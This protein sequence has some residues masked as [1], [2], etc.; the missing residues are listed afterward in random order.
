MA[1]VMKRV[2][3]SVIFYLGV[4][5]VGIGT[6][7]AVASMTMA[8]PTKPTWYNCNTREVFTPEKQ[9]WCDRWRVLQNATYWVP[10]RPDGQAPLVQVTLKNGRYQ[11]VKRKLFVQLVNER[12]WLAFGDLNGDG[13]QDAAVVLGV[14]SDPNGG[15]IGTFLSAVREVDNNAAAIAPIRLGDRIRLN[16]PITVQQGEVTVP[17]LT[18]TQVINR[19]YMIQEALIERGNP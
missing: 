6:N 14:A 15:K 4:S 10:S 16:G 12:N 1:G 8:Q 9:A 19:V 11:D 2:P 7:L 5:L 18:Q 3:A 13:K 17:F